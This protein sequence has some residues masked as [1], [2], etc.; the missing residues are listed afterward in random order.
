MFIERFVVRMLNALNNVP[1]AWNSVS[2]SWAP[3]ITQHTGRYVEPFS[4]LDITCF[5][6][7][8]VVRA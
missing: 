6:C 5:P 8:T 2:Y 4:I 3:A 7:N 1:A